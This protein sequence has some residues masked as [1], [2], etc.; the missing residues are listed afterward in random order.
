MRKT[1]NIN[2]NWEFSKDSTTFEAVNLPHTWNNLD[3][4]D[5]GADFLRQKCYYKKELDLTKS[6]SKVFIEFQGA[7]H[8]ANVTFN[9]VHLGEHRGGY[10]TFRY[11]L[12]ALIA[13]KNM[14]EVTV[15]N[16][17]DIPVYPQRADF[18]FFGGL[19]RDVQIIE[20]GSTHFDLEKFGSDAIF[21]TS[22]VNDENATVSVEAY[23][24][25]EA[26]G[27]EVSYE[28]V[29]AEGHV[30]ATGKA[31]ASDKVSVT[32]NV[33]KAILWN[34][35]INPYLYTLKACVFQGE[36]VLDSKEIEFGIRGFSVDSHKGFILN[37]KEYHL[38]GVSRHQ[39]RLDKGYAISREDHKQD[40]DLIQET[41]ATSIRLAHYQHDQFFYD[42]CDQRGM[43][44]WAEIPFITMF[45]EE[46]EAREN[47]I[48]QMEELIYQNY[49]HPSICFW[50]I[51]NEITIGGET[52]ALESNQKAL[53]ELIN[54]FDQ[55]RLTTLANVSFTDIGSNQNNLTDIIGYNHYFGWYGGELEDNE[56]WI[57]DFHAKYP[58]KPLCISEYGAEG[59]LA[60]HTDK[61]ECRDYTEEYH[62]VYHE[63]MLKIFAQRP[64]LWATYQWN[65]FDFAADAR[66]EGGVQG[67]NNKGLVTFDRTIKKD[68]FFAYKAFWSAEKF[69]HVTGRRYVDRA[70]ETATIKVYSNC[71]TVTLF[72]N[73]TEF[74]TL[75]ADKI[76][77]FPDVTLVMGDNKIKAV[78]CDYSDEITLRRC[79][80]PNESYVLVEDE[81]PVGEGVKN[82][83]EDIGE[84]PKALEFKE[85]YFSIKNTVGDIWKNDI[86]REMFSDII[87]SGMP[88]NK[89]NPAMMKMIE[90][91]KLEVVM[92][93]AGKK[94]PAG[95]TEFINAKL[96][97]IKK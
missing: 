13:D 20:V 94:L 44:T 5:G 14:L 51:T 70:S 58:E 42:L 75:S 34:G 56:E 81:T 15:D 68:A 31:D 38:H 28:V 90:G 63:H 7:N 26:A 2:A 86:A 85:G 54:G 61:P 47:T 88:G 95:A 35:M 78:A 64:F 18:T 37:E 76:F 3:G 46:K 91:M 53:V 72:V 87:A 4:Q 50:G 62:A 80:N 6:D 74:K 41:G 57:D 16:S 82:W 36:D 33:L 84:A 66:D 48:S 12:T 97:K 83:F 11:E 59:I 49:N 40:M 96:Q 22:K 30:V 8:I 9:G 52:E 29:D 19:Y 89:P 17:E 79:E 45:M 43:V 71:E 32:M 55:T 1:I 73:G 10:S 60:Y 69:V 21:V 77:I 23:V 67:R 92:K 24:V 65:M 93:M 39:D 25:G 27:V